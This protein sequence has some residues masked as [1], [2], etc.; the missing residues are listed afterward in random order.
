MHRRISLWRVICGPAW[1]A[2]GGHGQPD[3][4]PWGGQ[5]SCV[6]PQNSSESTCL[7][8][9]L[10]HNHCLWIL[11]SSAKWS[12]D[13]FS[14]PLCLQS[15]DCSG[16]GIEVSLRPCPCAPSKFRDNEVDCVWCYRLMAQRL[17]MT[18]TTCW[19]LFWGC[20]IKQCWNPGLS[21]HRWAS[22]P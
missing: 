17:G 19:S 11:R 9:P 6:L 16:A 18:N 7:L 1:P 22:F 5:P 4:Y 12:T 21:S 8:F 20:W 13:H 14:V 10:V 2:F 15:Q 3:W